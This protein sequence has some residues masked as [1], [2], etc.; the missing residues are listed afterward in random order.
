M[1]FTYPADLHFSCN[2]CALCCGDTKQKTRHIL[3]LESEAKI[4]ASQ[5]SRDVTDFSFRIVD[6]SPFGYEM[7]KTKAGKCVFLKEN[8]CAIYDVR[9]LICRFYPFELRFDKDMQLQVFDFTFE[10][11]G[12]GQGKDFSINDFE[13]LF[14]LAQERLP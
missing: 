5:T 2:R 1:D 3:L 6:K 8:Q 10:C 11:P 4:V 9:P 7:K 13:R 12:I 14:V